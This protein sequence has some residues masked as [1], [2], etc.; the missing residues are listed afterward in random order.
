[1]HTKDKLA[2]ALRDAGLAPMAEKAATGWYHDFLSPLAMPCQQLATD[3]GVHAHN[4]TSPRQAAARALL[5]RHMNGDFD[6]SRA[7]SEAWSASQ[8]GR[9]VFAGLTGPHGSEPE[10][11]PGR[12]QMGRLAMRHEG[13]MWVAYYAMPGTMQDAIPLGS[14]QMAFVASD[15]R[16]TAFMGLMREAVSDIIESATGH[17]PVWPEGTVAAPEHER[18]GHA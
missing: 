6:A 4:P 2:A 15:A 9:S 5:K 3:L 11:G 7:E 8:E 13:Q 16:K 1:M 12:Q 18:A 10:P 17:R 14:I